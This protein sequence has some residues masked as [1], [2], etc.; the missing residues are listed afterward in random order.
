MLDLG[1][2]QAPPT[3]AHTLSVLDD[4]GEAHEMPLAPLAVRTSVRSWSGRRCAGNGSLA[5]R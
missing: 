3:I 4:K 5:I 2:A 1:K